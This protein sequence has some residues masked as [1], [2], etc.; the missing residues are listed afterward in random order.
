[1]QSN[2]D[3][4]GYHRFRLAVVNLQYHK[5]IQSEL[6][7]FFLTGVDINLHFSGASVKRDR[8]SHPILSTCLA[9]SVN[10]SK[11]TV[12]PHAVRETAFE[13]IIIL[14]VQAL[15]DLRQALLLVVVYVCHPLGVAA[16]W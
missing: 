5:Y 15:H 2:I 10:R 4:L 13:Q 14:G 9:K 3:N 6:Q 7:C 16:L 11:L 8:L 1:M 12:P